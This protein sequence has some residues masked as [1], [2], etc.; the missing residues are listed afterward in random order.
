MSGRAP[1]GAMDARLSPKLLCR[2]VVLLL[3]AR[4]DAASPSAASEGC[5][6]VPEAFLSVEPRTHS[7]GEATGTLKLPYATSAV[8]DSVSAPAKAVATTPSA[9]SR[10]HATR[11]S[12]MH[13]PPPP[14]RRAWRAK[15]R[16]A[17]LKLPAARWHWCR[18]SGTPR[19]R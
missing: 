17:M 15:A 10:A 8:C 11:G 13:P 12:L 5:F 2:A 9:S 7:R 1:S 18:L 4:A 14:Q 16:G 19:A 6:G 3:L